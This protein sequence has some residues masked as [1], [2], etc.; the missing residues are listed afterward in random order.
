M[1]IPKTEKSKNRNS[2]K[3]ETAKNDEMRNSGGFT[4]FI[5]LSPKKTGLSLFCQES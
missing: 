1:K 4:F 5:C 2:Q 3:S